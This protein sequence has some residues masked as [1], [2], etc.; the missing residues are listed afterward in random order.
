MEIMHLELNWSQA[1][2]K[3]AAAS[4]CA[5]HESR[6]YKTRA[7]KTPRLRSSTRSAR[8][9]RAACRLHFHRYSAHHPST[10]RS[11]NRARRHAHRGGSGVRRLGFPHRRGQRDRA[12]PACVWRIVMHTEIFFTRESIVIPPLALPSREIGAHV[13]FQGIVREL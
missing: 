11:A 9:P 12:H 4:P 1:F 13:E 7:S 6:I 8:L 3:D 2:W 10:P 5:S